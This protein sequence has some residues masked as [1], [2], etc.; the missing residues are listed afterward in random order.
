M[1][2]ADKFLFFSKEIEGVRNEDVN[3]PVSGP[4][5]LDITHGSEALRTELPADTRPGISPENTAIP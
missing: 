2:M 1:T 5:T 4:A 3:S